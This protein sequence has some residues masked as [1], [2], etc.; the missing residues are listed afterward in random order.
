MPLLKIQSNVSVDPDK[1]PELLSQFS[2]TVAEALGKPERYVMVALEE[3][4]WGVLFDTLILFLEQANSEDSA[5]K[6]WP[7]WAFPDDGKQYY[8]DG[9]IRESEGED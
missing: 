7:C 4:D 3:Y 5:G 9:E 1:R 2:Q 8:Y 6:Y